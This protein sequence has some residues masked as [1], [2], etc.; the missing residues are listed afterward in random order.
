M[1]TALL[2]RHGNIR[3]LLAPPRGG[4]KPRDYALLAHPAS[5]DGGRGAARRRGPA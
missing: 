2:A 5:P 1:G 3:R 4:R